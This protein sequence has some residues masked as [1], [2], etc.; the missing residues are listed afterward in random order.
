MGAGRDDEGGRQLALPSAPRLDK[1]GLHAEGCECARCGLGFKPTPRERLLARQA[2][3][4]AQQREIEE[5]KAKQAG[6]PEARSL[7][8][9][10][11]LDERTKETAE[12]IKRQTAPVERPATPEELDE[13]RQL[14]GFKPRRKS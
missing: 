3:E 1:Y 10:E 5:A 13:L 8:R 12:W 4:R 9:R 2:F 7:S 14:H 6:T 11:R